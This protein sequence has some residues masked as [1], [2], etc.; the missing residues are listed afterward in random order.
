M[1][2]R[3]FY[4]VFAT[5]WDDPHVIDRIP[6]RGLQFSMPLSDHG[7][8]TFSATVGTTRMT[9]AWRAS[10][11]PPVSGIIVTRDGVPMWQGWIA[12]ETEPSEGTFSFTCKEWGARFETFAAVVQSW[13]QVNDHVMF[14]DV[15]TG[16]QGIANQNVQ[17]TVGSSL[18]ASKSD[19]TLHGWDNLSAAEVFTRIAE[20]EGGPEWYFGSSGTLD[21]PVRS[22]V[23]GDRLG[24]KT[25][26]DVLTY[27][28]G[29][30]GG[31]VIAVSRTRDTARSATVAIAVGDGQDAAQIRRTA[32]ATN[33]LAAGWPRMVRWFQHSD[34][35]RGDTLQRHANA[36]L[37]SC[38]G[39]ATGYSLTTLDGDP[40]WTDIGRGSTMRVVL[41]TDVYGGARP[42]VFESR[43][44]NLTVDVPDDG[45]A[46]QLTWDL[47]ETLE[48]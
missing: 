23:L 3:P 8:C 44:L 16:A 2:R 35:S 26:A 36:D 15:V 41:D 10:V 38:V 9:S 14:R 46:A 32:S 1:A 21:N 5:R 20:A 28:K 43:L 25:P 11:S 39:I 17:V 48:T 13:T 7:E 12:S 42:L 30:R 45:G 22:L 6:A 24:D 19:R 34:V 40:D 29:G 37:A 4:E 27:V 47:A 31:N 33:L 18:G